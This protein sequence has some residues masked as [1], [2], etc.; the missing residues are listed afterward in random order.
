M[1]AWPAAEACARAALQVSICRL[2]A[3][4]ATCGS[5]RW[6]A[7]Q[8]KGQLTPDSVL[9]QRVSGNGELAVANGDAHWTALEPLQGCAPGVAWAYGAHG[10]DWE[11]ALQRLVCARSDA[12]DLAALGLASTRLID[13]T[14]VHNDGLAALCA[15]Y[16]ETSA[17]GWLL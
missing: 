7:G 10:V 1:A 6:E 2:E 5:V 8:A 15:P 4:L 12:S 11:D 16:F 14:R 13:I 3:S 17:L 9:M